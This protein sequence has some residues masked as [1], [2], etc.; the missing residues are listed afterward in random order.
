VVES[1]DGLGEVLSR[2]RDDLSEGRWEPLRRMLD[3]ARVART[4][5]FTKSVYTGDPVAL[6]MLV[7]DRPGVLAEVTTAA[8]EIGANIEDLRIIHSTEGGKGRLEVV[9]AGEEQADILTGTLS[10]L[11][12][13]VE[14]GVVQ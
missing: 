7:P 9:V 10:G 2:V 5:A 3:D 11:G 4:S 6:W 14:R 8:G 1:L 13:H 12:Y